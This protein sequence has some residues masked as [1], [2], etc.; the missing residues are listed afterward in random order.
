[1]QTTLREVQAA[2]EEAIMVGDSPT[3]VLTARNAGAWVC[4]VTYGLGSHLLDRRALD[5]CVDSLTELASWA[6]R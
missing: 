6:G 1:V 5:L 4:G 3:D 2:P